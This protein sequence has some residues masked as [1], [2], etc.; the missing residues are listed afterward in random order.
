MKL[1]ICISLARRAQEPQHI[2]KERLLSSPY[3]ELRQLKSRHPFVLAAVKLLKN[4]FKSDTSV[5]VWW[6]PNGIRNGKIT[7][8]ADVLSS[9]TST[10]NHEE[11]IYPDN[12]A[13]GL[14]TSALA[15]FILFNIVQIMY[16]SHSSL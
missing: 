6:K 13:S 14:I 9:P 12:P 16:G 8:P 3:R 1:H 5:D 15:L 2:L 10:P 4:F 11:C 7:P